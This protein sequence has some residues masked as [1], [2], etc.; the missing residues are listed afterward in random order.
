L[1]RPAAA[2][3]AGTGPAGSPPGGE[4]HRRRRGDAVPGEKRARAGSRQAGPGERGAP[5]RPGRTGRRG[6]DS[7]TR[8]AILAAARARF[9]EAGYDR[10]TIRGIAGLAGVDPALVHHYY[11]TK[12]RLFAAAMELP[13]VPSDV[14]APILA[15]GPPGS[16]GTGERMLRTALSVWGATEVRATFLGLLRTAATSEQ[17]AEMLK[18][19]VSR[20]IL[21]LVAEAARAGGAGE[22]EARY[23]AGLVASQ[24]LGLAMTRY[25]LGLDPLAAAGDD[26]LAAAI[27]PTLDRYLTGDIG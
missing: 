25:V 10:A 6:G 21:S 26:Q 7:G 3:P 8:D 27:G 19:F 24:I 23:R 16:P 1:T 17:A 14:I 22:A 12:E 20:T 11:G 18:E 2:P 13:V 5:V 4:A 9:A 15:A